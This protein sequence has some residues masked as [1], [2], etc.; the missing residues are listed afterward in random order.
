MES[1]A[2][3]GSQVSYQKRV[4]YGKHLKNMLHAI[5]HTYPRSILCAPGSGASW[6]LSGRCDRR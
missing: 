3:Q 5:R 4:L 2:C 6:N 1:R